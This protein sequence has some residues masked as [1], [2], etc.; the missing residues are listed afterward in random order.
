MNPSNTTRYSQF[1]PKDFDPT[2][3][4]TII[5]GKGDYPILAAERIRKCGVPVC[6]IA[7]E[8]E[9]PLHFYESFAEDRRAMLKVGQI[10][11][12]LKTLKRFDTRYSMMIGQ[13]TPKRL[14]GGLSLDL[15]A[16]MMIA[17]LKERN[18]ET[19]FGSVIRE[20]DKIGIQT[21]DARSFL[22]DQ[23]ATE[24]IMTGGKVKIRQE[25]LDHGIRI[26]RGIAAIDVGQGVVVSKG[27]VLAAE[28]FEGTNHM[29]RR[30]ATFGADDMVF[31]KTIKRNQNFQID[32]PVF[33]IRTVEVMDECNIRVALL[34]ARNTIMIHKERVLEEARKRGITLI[35]YMPETHV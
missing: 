21:L 32:V 11:K 19:I 34:E 16:L 33:G 17:M 14:F 12:L 35:G 26:A 24:G 5:A 1:L 29:L 22:D 23:M 27:T 7:F 6:L 2:R 3:T 20:M 25:F 31:V 9:T 13:I 8:D 30:A 28:A 10:G 18:A 4:V 15:K